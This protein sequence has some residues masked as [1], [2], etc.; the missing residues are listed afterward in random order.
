M[1]II[2]KQQKLVVENIEIIAV[3][4]ASNMQ[5][6]DNDQVVL[7]SAIET[8]PNYLQVGPFLPRTNMN[9]Y[10]NSTLK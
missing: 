5:V 10:S 2:I 8:P 3:S 9:S 4:G 1:N 7:Y 6:G